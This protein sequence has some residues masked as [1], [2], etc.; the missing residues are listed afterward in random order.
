MPTVILFLS[1]GNDLYKYKLLL[2]ELYKETYKAACP[3]LA[4]TKINNLMNQFHTKDTHT[5]E[6][7]I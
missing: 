1:L 7:R 2:K 5:E 4:V 6:K 3:S